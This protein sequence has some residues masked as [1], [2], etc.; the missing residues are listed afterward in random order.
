M[1]WDELNAPCLPADLATGQLLVATASFYLAGF[2]HPFG[3]VL[4]YWSALY[5]VDWTNQPVMYW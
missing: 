3:W 2:D 1:L 5:A 4:A